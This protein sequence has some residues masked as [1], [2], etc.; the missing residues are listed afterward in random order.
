MTILKIGR[1][2]STPLRINRIAIDTIYNGG[3]SIDASDPAVK[4][5]LNLNAGRWYIMSSDTDQQTPTAS[6]S[7]ISVAAEAGNAI[8]VTIQLKDATGANLR[9]SRA[10]KGWF[11]DSSDGVDLINTAPD[12]AVTAGTGLI[13]D[14]TGDKKV[15]TIVTSASGQVTMTINESTNR[16]AFYLVLALPTGQIKVSSAID[17]A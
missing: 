13:I 17:F 9:A 14:E 2:S 5:D 10:I 7:T 12:G 8:T 16:A 3:T 15:F 1:I 11:S 6:A 4:R